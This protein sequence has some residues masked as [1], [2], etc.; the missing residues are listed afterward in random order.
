MKLGALI[1]KAPMLC[2]P[3]SHAGSFTYLEVPF[4]F[5]IFVEFC[6]FPNSESASAVTL[7]ATSV[8]AC[9]NVPSARQ[10]WCLAG[11]CLLPATLHQLHSLPRPVVPDWNTVP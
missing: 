3:H 1:Y 8:S 9:G 7:T 2:Q 6:S 10:A 4:S 5:L 11:P